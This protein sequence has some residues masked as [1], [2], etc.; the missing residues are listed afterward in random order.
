MILVVTFVSFWIHL[1][2]LEFMRQDEGYSRF[3]AYM[4]L[5]VASMLTLAARGQSAPAVSRMGGRGPVQ[6]SPDRI[7]VSRS[8]ERLGGSQSVHRHARRRYGDVAGR[9]SAVHDFGTL[10]IQDLM[11]R[12]SEQWAV[13][14][15][16]AMAAALLLLGG[17][18]GK[19][20]QLPLQVWLPDAMAG[21][22][23]T[24]ALIHAAT[25]VTAGVYLGCAHACAV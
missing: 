2:S 8:G 16:L 21:P 3:F 19:S 15:T 25:M 7:L 12:A 14:S 13:G 18:V 10:Q 4:N 22:T 24:S 20:A 17:A 9:V 5:F 11:H 6:L 1:Y 23:P